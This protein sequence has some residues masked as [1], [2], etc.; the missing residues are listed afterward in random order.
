MFNNKVSELINQV[1]SQTEIQIKW[2]FLVCW[3]CMFLRLLNETV[4]R[5]DIMKD[6]MRNC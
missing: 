2:I 4:P 6:Q 5:K 1:L 3:K